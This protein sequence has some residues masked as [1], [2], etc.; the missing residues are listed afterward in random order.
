[1]KAIGDNLEA[2]A[3]IKED[4]KKVFKIFCSLLKHPSLTNS[5]DTFLALE[6]PSGEAVLAPTTE[7]HFSLEVSNISKLPL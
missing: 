1:M 6:I 3:Y 5:L 4:Y 2:P 7:T